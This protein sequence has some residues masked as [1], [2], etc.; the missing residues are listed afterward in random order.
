V[1]KKTKATTAESTN[2]LGKSQGNLTAAKITKLYTDAREDIAAEIRQ[3]WKNKSF[4]LGE[5]WIV[6]DDAKSE[7]NFT[8]PVATKRR[9]QATNNRIK[10]ALN[11]TVSRNQKTQLTFEVQ[12]ESADDYTQEGA[13]KGESILRQKHIDDDWETLKEELVTATALGGT[14]ALIT[15]WDPN[16]D[17]LADNLPTG[18]A[19][20]AVATIADFVVETGSLDAKRARWGIEKQILPPEQV[21]SMFKMAETPAADGSDGGP[22]A[23]AVCNSAPELRPKV[24][25]QVLWYYERPNHLR[26]KGAVAAVVGKK[27]VWQAEWPFPFKDRLN[28]NVTRCIIVPK[29][30]TG[31]TYISDAISVQRQYNHLWTK[32]HEARNRTLGSK[33]LVDS[34]HAELNDQLNDDPAIPIKLAPGTDAREPHY[35]EPPKLPPN[36]FQEIEALREELDDMLGVHDISRGATPANS[37]DSGYGLSL[38]AENDATPAGRLAGEMARAFAGAASN[39]LELYADKV[40]AKRKTIITGGRGVN[41]TLDWKGE[42][43]AGQTRVVVPPDSILPRSHAGMLKMATDLLQNKPDWFP[44]PTSWLKIATVP[45]FEDI[46]AQMDDDVARADYENYL[47]AQGIECVPETFDDDA[48]HIQWHHHHMKSSEFYSYPEKVKNIFRAH[49]DA[50]QQNAAHKAGQATGMQALHPALGTTPYGQLPGGPPQQALNAAQPQLPPSGA[51]AF[52]PQL[53]PGV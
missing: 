6:W 45:G 21:Q 17:E 46:Q 22:F 7:I 16:A 14:A 53:P 3:F 31:A 33:L 49:C 2:D 34:R 28:F 52:V 23:S 5:Q 9:E 12:S 24:G 40:K 39:I 36:T 32:I 19:L 8:E 11:N 41:R 15:K 13:H 42:D 38:L 43:L 51:D 27:I 20:L 37:P 30:W 44:N 26:K 47:M 50:H 18:D 25:T 35:L 1:A 29:R 10:P 48:K 4:W